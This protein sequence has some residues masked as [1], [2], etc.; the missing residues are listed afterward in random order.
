ME[1]GNEEKR[2]R[3]KTRQKITTITVEEL[4]NKIWIWERKEW[5]RGGRGEERREKK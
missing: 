2:K 3:R 4:K 1:G 5:V